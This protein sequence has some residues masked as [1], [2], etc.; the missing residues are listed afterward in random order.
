MFNYKNHNSYMIVNFVRRYSK[1]MLVFIGIPFKNMNNK[2][3]ENI[4]D[5][6]YNHPFQH[7]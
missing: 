6:N 3:S 7:L 4:I 2:I 5:I 1:I